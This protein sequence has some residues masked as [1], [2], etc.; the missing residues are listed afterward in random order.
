MSRGED[1]VGGVIYP[2]LPEGQI[3]LWLIVVMVV[4]HVLLVAIPLMLEP[5]TTQQPHATRTPTN[6]RSEETAT[7]DR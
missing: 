1:T 4:L 5:H 6:L 3:L 2:Q 7:P